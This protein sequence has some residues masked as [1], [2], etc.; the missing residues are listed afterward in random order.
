[1]D[2]FSSDN[3]SDD[4]VEKEVYQEDK[5]EVTEDDPEFDL[6]LAKFTD[7]V[8]QKATKEEVSHGQMLGDDAAEAD[9]DFID[10]IEAL[11]KDEP[12][13]TEVL[14]VDESEKAIDLVP[15]DG[16]EFI[17]HLA[18]AVELNKG[19][20]AEKTE[21]LQLEESEK[22]TD[23][24]PSEGA[25]EVHFHPAS[26][27]VN[28]NFGDDKLSHVFTPSKHSASKAHFATKRVTTGVSDNKENIGSG[29]KLVVMQDRVKVPT[30]NTAVEDECE[31]ALTDLSVRKL[32]KLLKEKLEITNKSSKNEQQGKEVR[33]LL[34]CFF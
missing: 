21:V 32:S 8:L 7:L 1:M 26:L 13:E 33:R 29:T 2:E 10:K 15:S 4:K 11:N 12:A 23:L 9:S 24:V 3:G 14:Q 31:K 5:D 16:T 17:D 22:A 20:S 6:T 30:K 25:E 28:A 18:I 27:G 34:A 19:E